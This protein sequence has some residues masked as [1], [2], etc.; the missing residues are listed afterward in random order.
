MAQITNLNELVPEDIVFVYGAESTEYTVPGDLDGETVFKLF[1]MFGSL[2]QIMQA[3]EGTLQP[4]KVNKLA[5]DV[6]KTLLE[7]FQIRHPELERLPFGFK[8]MPIVIRTILSHLGLG[9]GNS[10]AAPTPPRSPKKSSRPKRGAGS[11]K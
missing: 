4:A 3:P 6:D 1:R 7:L 10:P 8:S 9:P 5:R 2:A 11:R